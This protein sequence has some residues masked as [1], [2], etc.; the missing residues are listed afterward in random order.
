MSRIGKKPIILDADLKINLAKDK[1]Q[2]EGPCGKMELPIPSDIEVVHTA[3]QIEVKTLKRGS[4]EIHGL[5]RTLLQNAVTGVK[6]Q[7]SRTLELVGVG[8]RAESDGRELILNLGF[9]HPVKI[10]APDNISFKVNENKIVVLGVD[11]Y[12]VGET[13]AT[14]HRLKPPEPYKGKGI[15]YEKEYIRKKLGKAAKAVGTASAK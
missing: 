11:K 9:S 7:W 13:A 2:I 8:Y 14:I 15:R 3:N 10:Q 6:N 12:L 1:I 4:G 5:F